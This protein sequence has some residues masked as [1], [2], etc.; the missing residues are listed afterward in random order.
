MKRN[1]STLSLDDVNRFFDALR[2][3]GYDISSVSDGYHSFKEL[4]E[5]RLLYNAM[6][7]NEWGSFNVPLY[8]VH[9]SW[10]HYDGQFCFG[11][12]WF[13]VCAELP[14]GQIS[15][16]YEKQYWDYFHKVPFAQSAKNKF[17]GHTSAESSR[18]MEEFLKR[19]IQ[20]NIVSIQQ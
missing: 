2:N 7:F 9:R 8:D 10:R 18:R 3:Q 15:N 13:I 11:G 14:T 1:Q 17:D 6:L 16:H 19:K 12:G 4:Y 20:G 5:F